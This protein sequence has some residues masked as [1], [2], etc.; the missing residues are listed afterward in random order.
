M[1]PN[2]WIT[3]E[4]VQI[5]VE[6]PVGELK[7]L[8]W[9]NSSGSAMCEAISLLHWPQMVYR[10]SWPIRLKDSIFEYNS[11]TLAIHSRHVSGWKRPI[12][13]YI[14]NMEPC[15]KRRQ[16]RKRAITYNGSIPYLM[17]SCGSHWSEPHNTVVVLVFAFFASHISLALLCPCKLEYGTKI[18]AEFR[19]QSYQS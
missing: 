19:D 1:Y 2:D 12:M 5:Q 6:N 14:L 4:R 11:N 16:S 7:S 3:C 8:V 17:Y 9:H 13:L 15:G 18:D 10:K